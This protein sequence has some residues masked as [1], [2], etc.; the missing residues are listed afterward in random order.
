MINV[1]YLVK[2]TILYLVFRALDK[3]ELVT[4]ISPVT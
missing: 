2:L 3:N 4:N 1:K